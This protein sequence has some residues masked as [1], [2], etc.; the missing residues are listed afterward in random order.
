LGLVNRKRE[1]LRLVQKLLAKEVLSMNTTV[2]PDWEVLLAPFQS[3]FSAPGFRYFGVFVRVLAH[4]DRRLWVTQ[5]VLSGL[6]TRHWT[7]FY[8]FLRSSAWSTQEVTNVL[9]RQCL[10][11][12]I[13]GGRVLLGLDATVCAKSGAHFE[14]LGIHHDPMNKQHPRH[15]SRGH[16]FVCLAV[17]AE[18]SVAHWVALFVSCAL[19]IQKKGGD[20]EPSQAG[21]QGAQSTAEKVPAFATKLQLAVALLD[22]LPTLANLLVI[23]VCD[24]A[25]AKQKFVTPVCTS[26]KHVCSR[27]RRDC[28]FYDLPPARLPHQRGAERKYGTKHKG[29][30]WIAQ[31]EDWQTVTLGLYG[32]MRTIA[33]KSRIVLLRRF[34][35]RARLVAVR[36]SADKTVFL[37]CTDTSMSAEAVVQTYCARFAIETGFRDA[38]QSFGLS[39][40]QVR[41]Q[42]GFVRLVHLCLWAQTLLRLR[43]WNQAPAESYGGWR[44][45]VN[46]LTLSQQKRLSHSQN[47]LLHTGIERPAQPSC[48]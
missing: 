2:S 17:L 37:F 30:A 40:Y 44:K 27:L 34:K 18:Q 7:N 43:C 8:R 14:A 12:V 29:Q 11:K 3:L 26:G 28:V 25:Y 31:A 41:N 16:C 4:L 20:K 19:Y 35:V 38:K 9:Y 1:W 13:V 15:L 5:V 32:R 46:Y 22:P 45:K 24:G 42:T 6:L 36:W 48:Q 47:A 33:L 10:D 21:D 23:V 39:T